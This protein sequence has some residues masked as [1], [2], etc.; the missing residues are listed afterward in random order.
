M[1]SRQPNTVILHPSHWVIGTGG[2]IQETVMGD[3]VV[4]RQRAKSLEFRDGEEGVARLLQG[5]FPSSVYTHD[6]EPL[7]ITCQ[8]GG[9]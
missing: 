7:I 9:L 4:R 2:E 6:P 1:I 3:F 8:A 5:P